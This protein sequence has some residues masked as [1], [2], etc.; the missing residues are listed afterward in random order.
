MPSRTGLKEEELLTLANILNSDTQEGNDMVTQLW[1]EASNIVLEIWTLD[2][3]RKISADEAGKKFQ[4]LMPKLKA[5][6]VLH[7]ILIF[8]VSILCSI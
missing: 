6:L 2:P 7:A 4:G 3:F 8:S 5:H 1:K